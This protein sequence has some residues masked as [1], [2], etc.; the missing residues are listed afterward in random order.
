M[1]PSHCLFFNNLLFNIKMI[2]WLQKNKTKIL[3]FN[4]LV[5]MWKINLSTFLFY[6]LRYSAVWFK[7]L[8]SCF[9]IIFFLR[10]RAGY[11]YIIQPHFTTF[12]WNEDIC[13]FDVIILIVSKSLSLN[14][15]KM[16]N[17]VSHFKYK[18]AKSSKEYHSLK[19]FAD[20]KI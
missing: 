10:K 11:R 6:F 20:H 17:Y 5:C 1:S 7:N 2:T 19:I 16:N 3:S 8:L 4:Q 12:I 18:V 14:K 9:L 15:M 13:L